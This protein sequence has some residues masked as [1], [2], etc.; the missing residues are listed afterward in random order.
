MS[1]RRAA[2]ALLLSVLMSLPVMAGERQW[3]VLSSGDGDD[4]HE[5]WQV[6]A[7][8]LRALP[9]FDPVR[10]EPPLSVHQATAAAL[11]HA[12]LRYPADAFVV[13]EV[14]LQRFAVGAAPD[15]GD[16]A[17]DWVYLVSLDYNA[18]GWTQMVPVLLDGSIVLSDKEQP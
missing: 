12:R 6:S 13:S 10:A 5:R 15:P 14:S 9:A 4:T 3:T 8:R 11:A 17:R 18:K 16:A 2:V 7:T 1:V